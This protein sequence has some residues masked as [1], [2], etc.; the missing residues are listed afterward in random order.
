MWIRV[1]AKHDPESAYELYERDKADIRQ[2]RRTGS[3]AGDRAIG[4][5]HNP[6]DVRVRP[7]LRFY[8][9]WLYDET[10]AQR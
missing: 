5:R 10:W 1:S 7:H 2:A 4:K 8:W 6:Y 9:D 3:A